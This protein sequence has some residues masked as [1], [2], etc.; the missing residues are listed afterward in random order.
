MK[1]IK[2]LSVLVL[3]VS[4]SK[5]INI[6]ELIIPENFEGSIMVFYGVK[7]GHNDKDINNKVTYKIP[8]DG[9]YYTQNLF[10]HGFVLEQYY[11]DAKGEKKK[12]ENIVFAKYHKTYVKEKLYVVED[13]PSLNRFINE[14]K[15]QLDCYGLIISSDTTKIY[16]EEVRKKTEK[17][18]DSIAN[19]LIKNNLVHGEKHAFKR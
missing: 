13:L 3:L 9:I 14:E 18:F 17:K 7:N 10:G 15:G 2:Y 19:Y 5:R 11:Y 16:R 1:I 4:C 6:T 12:I 8:K